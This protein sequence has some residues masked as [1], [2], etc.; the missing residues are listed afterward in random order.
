MRSGVGWPT[1]R[2]R[3]SGCCTAEN[4]AASAPRFVALAVLAAV[5]AAWLSP[6]SAGAAPAR[7]WEMVSPPVKNGTDAAFLIGRETAT[8]GRD[9]SSVV[10]R[11][12]GGYADAVNGSVN[13][14]RAVRSSSGW[15]TRA[16]T[17]PLSAS[18][19]TIDSSSRVVI[20]SGDTELAILSQGRDAV[21]PEIPDGEFNALFLRNARDGSLTWLTKPR[22]PAAYGGETFALSGVTGDFRH[23][24]FR[25]NPEDPATRTVRMVD[26]DSA[27]S[28]GS[29]LYEIVDGELRAVGVLPDGS[30]PV[31]GAISPGRE[32]NKGHE[33]KATSFNNQVSQ[34]G[35]R[36]VF[37][38]PD[39]DVTSDRSPRQ[40]YLRIGGRRTVLITRSML[41]GM[42]ARAS[43]TFQYASPDGSVVWFKVA[44]RLTADAPAATDN[45]Y[46]FDVATETVTYRPEGGEP[47]ASSSDGSV[48]I[49]GRLDTS[50]LWLSDH[51][52][53]SRIAGPVDLSLVGLVEG[54][55]V[56]ITEDGSRFVFLSDGEVEPG[57]FNNR[58]G[59]AEL[60]MYDVPTRTL[61]CVSCPGP[62][63]VS[64]GDASIATGGSGARLDA[65]RAITA[66][67]RRVYFDTPTPL[68][69][70]DTNSVRDV[71]EWDDG[72][73]RLISEPG[74]Y[75]TVIGDISEDGNDV[76]VLTRNRLVRADTDGSVDLY[77]ARVGGGFPEPPTPPAC[78]SQCQGPLAPVPPLPLPA[79][80]GEGRGGNVQE[81]RSKAPGFK[82]QKI[83]SR[84]KKRFARTGRL[85]LVVNTAGDG[86]VSA[87]ARARFGRRWRTIS[88]AVRVVSDGG[89]SVL[90]LRLS[91]HA[92]ARLAD[93]G[94]LRLR[95]V[96]TYSRVA[97]P[98][99]LAFVL[100]AARSTAGGRPDA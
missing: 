98:K 37:K 100:R 52:V 77:D 26:E 36:I 58:A 13:D 10:F 28:L 18:V 81:P 31:N 74:Q 24:V 57:A 76:F 16:L 73:L 97:S 48:F 54:K 93:A 34:D 88:R 19:V 9:G 47:L 21:I 56:R 65:S 27:R 60:Y 90:G 35:S 1:G 69:R 62:Q 46:Q 53:E 6:G 45:R 85:S 29:G 44:D 33:L 49:Y 11:A 59:W 68:L 39:P 87:V 67:G 15:V 8:A 89:S 5:A 38:S 86:A 3:G 94:T 32:L 22:V 25:A 17:P 80:T 2:F 91:R 4:Q 78:D 12:A 99:H 72:D 95:V 42:P 82:V 92:R 40:L 70:A 66:D 30:I 63:G 41:T 14:Y 7:G 50:D 83:G 61:M 51:G 55:E 79:T 43:A 71:Y 64:Q 75:G 96:V 84:A 20:G 23:V